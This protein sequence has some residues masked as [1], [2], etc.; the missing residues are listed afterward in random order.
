MDR[1]GLGV[2]ELGMMA[3][4]FSTG[5]VEEAVAVH[6]TMS[7]ADNQRK[8]SFPIQC[9]LSDE[10]MESLG[11]V[12]GENQDRY[13]RTVTLPE[14]WELRH[15][16]QMHNSLFDEKGRYRAWV[17]MDNRPWDRAA[18][19]S[20]VERFRASEYHDK[21]NYSLCGAC[22]IDR[23]GT[24]D[25]PGEQT[26]IKISELNVIQRDGDSDEAYEKMWAEQDKLRELVK[27]YETILD[28][29]Y[30]DHKNILA[31]W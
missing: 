10:D 28:E 16:G 22:I 12:I 13:L 2:A 25:K 30:P 1:G 17:M 4:A 15:D 26:Y 5:N 18:S 27:S 19:C 3:V 29:Q 21:D 6:D 20:F 11:F 24:E 23:A 31:Y 8:S 14:G 7:A 9:N